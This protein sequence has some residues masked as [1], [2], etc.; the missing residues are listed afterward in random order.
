MLFE[1][2]PGGEASDRALRNGELLAQR[3]R[4]LASSLSDDLAADVATTGDQLLEQAAD[5]RRTYTST[6]DDDVI[7]DLVGDTVSAIAALPLSGSCRLD[8]LQDSST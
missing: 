8:G 4:D 1:A 2:R 3:Y 6:F 7:A 5:A